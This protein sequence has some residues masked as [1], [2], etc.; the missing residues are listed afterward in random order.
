MTP[1]HAVFVSP[2]AGMTPPRHRAF[3]YYII[4]LKRRKTVVK[5]F[6]VAISLPLP[7]FFRRQ[8]PRMENNVKTH[9]FITECGQQYVFKVLIVIEISIMSIIRTYELSM[10]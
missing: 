9:T 7:T 5:K 3:R 1:E 2:Q 6:P 10:I 4:S 8:T